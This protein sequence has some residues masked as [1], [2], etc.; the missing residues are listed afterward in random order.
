M[1]RALVVAL[2]AASLLVAGCGDK[3]A[4]APSGATTASTLVDREG[5]G[6]LERGPGEPLPGGARVLGSVGMVTDAHLRDEESPARLPVL[7]RIGG[8]FESAFRPQEALMPHVLTAAVRSLN[9]LRLD[10]VVVSGDLADSAQR[11][12]LDQAVAVLDGGGVDPDSG[13]PGYDGVQDAGNPD[14]LIYRPDVDAPRHPGLLDR[15]QRRF[16]S[17]GLRA[18][19]Y[20]ALGNHDLLVAGEI[21]P[22][23]RLRAAAAGSRAVVALPRDLRREDIDRE[24]TL[25]AVLDGTFGRSARVPADAERRHLTPGEY[26]D[27]LARS[28]AGAPA[29]A[30]ARQGGRLDYVF[31]AGPRLRGIVLDTVSRGGGSGGVLAP[32]QREWVRGQLARAGERRVIVFSHHPLERTEGASG[33]LADL[34][35]SERVAALASGHSHRH[36]IRRRGRLWVIST[37]ALTDFPQQTRVL[38]LVRTAQGDEALETFVVDHDGR[39]DAGVARDLAFLDAQGGRPQGFAGSRADRNRRLALPAR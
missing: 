15:A 14:P 22:D 36:G 5:D 19:W 27:R 26:L 29:R 4:G 12:E 28:G 33:L 24:R 25:D 21:A 31:D 30:A 11:N 34:E 35:A 16:A 32:G 8:D 2:A 38:R 20:P 17:P 13:R 18:P 39:A 37:A 3:E 6:T 23:A 9:A 10:G 1:S 7:D